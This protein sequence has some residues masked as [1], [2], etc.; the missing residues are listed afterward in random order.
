MLGRVVR[1]ELEIFVSVCGFPVDASFYS[2][3]GIPSCLGVQKCDRSVFFFYC[4]SD[5][6]VVGVKMGVELCKDN[7]FTS[8][9]DMYTD[10][11]EQNSINEHIYIPDINK[12]LDNPK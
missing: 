6:L 3:F 5:V 10:I 7:I 4:K 8:D 9:T 1:V 11:R 12:A 2:S